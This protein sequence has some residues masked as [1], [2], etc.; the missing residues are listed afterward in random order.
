MVGDNSLRLVQLGDLSEWMF[1]LHASVQDI[2]H[3][4][5]RDNLR[6]IWEGYAERLHDAAINANVAAVGA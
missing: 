1:F 3:S 5:Q 4:Q 6:V 2:E